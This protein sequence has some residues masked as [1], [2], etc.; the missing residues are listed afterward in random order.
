MSKIRPIAKFYFFKKRILSLTFFPVFQLV[1]RFFLL[2]PILY[3]QFLLLALTPQELI[4][5]SKQ[6]YAGGEI[7][8][9]WNSM[10]REGLRKWEAE[11]LKSLKI[12]KGKCLVMGA[13]CGRESIELAKLGW[14]VTGIEEIDEMVKLARIDAKKRGLSIVY[15]KQD[16]AMP[17]FADKSF[18]LAILFFMMYSS[19]P[20]RD[21]RV[22][23]LKKVKKIL[24]PDGLF[25]F[26]FFLDPS[27]ENERFFV[28]KRVFAKI[29]KGNIGYQSG[30]SLTKNGY[31]RHFCDIKE[32]GEE[33]ESAGLKLIKTASADPMVKSQY[34]IAQKS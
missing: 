4:E 15:K 33:V 24:K 22:E 26:E 12:K 34:M 5:Y 27:R 19:I 25:I 18:E 17:D 32:I 2:L 16:F 10:N 14:Q 13:G 11:V 28:L 8:S 9:F 20:S 31:F 23:M 21:L 1:S 3:E 6:C 7:V 29:L 30:D